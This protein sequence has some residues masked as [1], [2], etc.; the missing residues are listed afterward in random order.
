MK[1]APLSPPAITVALGVWWGGAPPLLPTP[2]FLPPPQEVAS[3]LYTC[4]FWAWG[5]WEGKAAASSELCSLLLGLGQG[6][7]EGI[8]KPPC[9]ISAFNIFLNGGGVV[10]D[11]RTAM[12]FLF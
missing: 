11:H 7:R 4:H 8:P 5:W 10:S 2:P 12:S 3:R 1:A 9:A 6:G